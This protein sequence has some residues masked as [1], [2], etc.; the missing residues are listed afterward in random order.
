MYNAL[1]NQ[2]K[3]HDKCIL[4]GSDNLNITTSIINDAFDNLNSV[5]LC[6]GPAQDGG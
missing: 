6:I 2:S 5:D 4:I 3:E 1:I